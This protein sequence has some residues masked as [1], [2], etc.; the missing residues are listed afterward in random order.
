MK[1]EIVL[2]TLLTVAFVGV[3]SAV[4]IWTITQTI[5]QEIQGTST[6]SYVSTITL[7][8]GHQSILAN[9]TASKVLNVT[10]YVPNLILTIGQS[11]VQ[12]ASI[13]TMYSVFRLEVRFSGTTTALI[14]MDMRTQTT[15]N[16]TITEPGTYV[17]DYYF[18]YCP[19]GIGTVSYTINVGVST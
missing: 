13:Q 9:Y 14:K 12:R 1:R 3:V 5:T 4:T 16:A 15:A 17:F 7:P 6:V 8:K 10:T 11:E 2:A 18:E 19:V